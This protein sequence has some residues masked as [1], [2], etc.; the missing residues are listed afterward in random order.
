VRTALLLLLATLAAGCGA[1]KP[2][3]RATTQPSSERVCE[4]AQ[5]PGFR[6]CLR[7]TPPSEPTIERRTDSG[8]KVIARSLKPDEPS[9]R[10]YDVSL[11]PDRKTLVA[12][13]GYPCD[14]AVV[15]FV[16][17]SGGRPRLVTGGTDWRHAPV[18]RSLGWMPGGKARVRVYRDVHRSRIVL[19]DPR[20]RPRAPRPVRP[21]GC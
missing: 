4:A 21:T 8:W 2:A 16:P 19:F 9:A 5:A 15:V 17:A 18:T 20:V 7:P 10:W 1:G 12:D 11:S 13:W 6:T 14:S 3:A